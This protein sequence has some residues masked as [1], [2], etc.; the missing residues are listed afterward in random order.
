MSYI[1]KGLEE[2]YSKM[3]RDEV[4]FELPPVMGKCV[5]QLVGD[6]WTK[7]KSER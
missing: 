4:G 7:V 2:E 6:I 1:P 3:V 5:E